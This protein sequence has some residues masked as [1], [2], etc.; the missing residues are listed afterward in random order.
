MIGGRLSEFGEINEDGDEA[1]VAL[2][3][4][5]ILSLGHAAKVR[6]EKIERVRRHPFLPERIAKDLHLPTRPPPFPPQEG[7]RPRFVPAPCRASGCASPVRRAGF[8]PVPP[9]RRLA[10]ELPA[11]RQWRLAG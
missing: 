4:R 3:P 5:F 7:E 2:D 1:G 11:A 6:A 8:R 9:G 10:A